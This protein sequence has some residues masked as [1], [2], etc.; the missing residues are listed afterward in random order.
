MPG[1][2]NWT[3]NVLGGEPLLL[4]NFTFLDTLWCWGYNSGGR[5]ER[6]LQHAQPG[7]SGLPVRPVSEKA[8]PVLNR[9]GSAPHGPC[10]RHIPYNR[11][12][13][14]ARLWGVSSRLR[15]EQQSRTPQQSC[16][17]TR[18]RRARSGSA[19]ERRVGVRF[20][21]GFQTRARRASPRSAPP[22]LPQSPRTT[23]PGTSFKASSMRLMNR[24]KA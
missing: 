5:R 4:H 14:C 16:A 24:P 6:A 11:R 17:S 1:A 19:C 22:R 13:S 12:H 3:L 7:M 10:A 15:L 20:A 23:L 18:P 21:F 2:T 9:A 8:L